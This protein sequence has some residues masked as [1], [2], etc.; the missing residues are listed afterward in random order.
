MCAG[1]RCAVLAGLLTFAASSGAAEPP[2]RQVLILQ[3]FDRGN[4]NLDRFTGNF[5]VDLEQRTGGPVNFV[6]V[7]VGQTGL[8]GA[9]EQSVVD[10]ISSIFAD[11]PKPDLI[12]TIA[13]PASVFARKYRKQLFPDAPL[14]FASVDQRFLGDAQLR[15]NDTAVAAL[16]DFPAIVEDILRLLPQTKQVFMVVGNGPIRE[17]WRHRLEEQFRQ[18]RGRVTFDW[19]DDLTFPA[20]VRRSSSLPGNSAIYF[21]TLGTD[22]SGA[23][24]ADERV[25]ADLHASANAPLFAANDV[26]LGHGIVGGSLLANDELSRRTSDVAYRILTGTSPGDVR[27]P[28]QLPGQP[29]FDWRELER[30]NIPESRL[31]EGSLVKFRDPTLWHAYRGTVLT[32]IGALLIQAMLIVGLLLERRARHRAENAS[33]MNLS[34]AADVSRRETMSAL[35]SSITHELGQPLSAII[36]NT[37]ALQLMIK[38]SATREEIGEILSDI[39]SEGILAAD[40]IDR[41]RT[42]M[43]SRQL[44]M[45]P[46][47]LL[48]VVNDA[49]AL[50]AH[51]MRA[52][53]VEVSVSVPASSGEISGDPVLLQQVFLILMMNAMDAMAPSPPDQR[54]IQISAEVSRAHIE[55]SVSDTGPGLPEDLIG[56]LF[57]PFL[58]T[59]P[60][61]LGIGL[62][63]ARTLVGAHGGSITARNNPEGGAIFIVKLRTSKKHESLPGS[64]VNAGA[65]RQSPNA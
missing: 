37:H 30:W 3:S 20:I 2:V 23:A 55:V 33:R 9:P 35:T 48:T 7:V 21:I 57:T 25:L 38:K 28:P 16:N 42:M 10:Y 8:V 51:D 41:H 65:G 62:A 18:F 15:E 64:P 61:G 50:V 22:A 34:L 11:R 12:V 17:F 43:R 46:V 44:Q 1:L 53:Q 13:G 32:A 40:I 60:H 31:P 45:K 4:L 39:Q 59:K 19:F 47:D 27:V 29:V 63:I 5:R 24:Y 36:H 6:Q 52:R 54:H 56:R 14:L 26:F 58:T 49:V